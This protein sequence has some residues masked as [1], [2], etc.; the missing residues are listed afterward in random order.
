MGRVSGQ[1]GED[2]LTETLWHEGR[3]AGAAWEPG[4]PV[5]WSV[6][7]D[8]EAAAGAL[9]RSP[10]DARDLADFAAAPDAAYRL[11]RRRLTR[12]LL[13]QLAGVAPEDI[14]FGRTGDGAP[15]V[16][17]PAGWHVSVAGRAGHA[18]IGLAERPIGV[19][20][21][22]LDAAP[23]LW[24]MLTA[25]EAER[26]EALAPSDRPRAWLRA[27][28]AKEAHAKRWRFA[29]HA[30]PASIET[31]I[32]AGDRLSAGSTEGT[33]LVFLREANGRIEAAAL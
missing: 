25:T 15:S 20:A 21:E 22:P 30:D 13:A 16:L 6:R 3:L 5:L 24:D 11:L 32:V 31:E 2:R 10:H 29:R 9:A 33:S 4:R 19:D 8:S 26:I 14:L 1:A 23:P 17:S 12:A 28:T 27:W 18:L 7:L